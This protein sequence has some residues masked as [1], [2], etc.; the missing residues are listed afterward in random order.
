M[1]IRPDDPTL[2]E[3]VRIIFSGKNQQALS[4]LVSDVLPLF[5][6]DPRLGK[7]F[8]VIPGSEFE[9]AAHRFLRE[10]GLPETAWSGVRPDPPALIISCS[11]S[12]ELFE[13]GAKFMRL[14]HG[15]GSN[16]TRTDLDDRVYGLAPQQILHREETP[17]GERLRIPDWLPLAGEAAMELLRRNCPEAVPAAEVVG[18]LC[19]E[20]LLLSSGRERLRRYRNA[21]GIKRDQKLVVVS[22]T[23]GDESLFGT[24]RLDLVRELLASLPMDRFR[25]GVVPHPNI[26]NGRGASLRG[27]LSDQ[28]RNGLIM[29]PQHD[30]WRALLLAADVVVGDSGSVTQYAAAIGKPVLLGAFGWD[31]MTP[32]MPLWDFGKATP[33]LE[34]GK[35]FEPQIWAAIERGQPFDLGTQLAGDLTPS[36]TLFAKTYA[37]LDLEPPENPVRPKYI[38]L[39]RAEDDREPTTAWNFRVRFSGGRAHWERFPVSVHREASDTLVA[40]TEC[41]SREVLTLAKVLLCHDDV[42]PFEEARRRLEDLR[43]EWRHSLVRSVRTGEGEIL[44][45]GARHRQMRVRCE[46]ELLDI[47]PAALH[48]WLMEHPA[49][50][51]GLDAAD[52]FVRF[53]RCFEPPPT[54]LSL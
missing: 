50:S 29:P 36:E 30:L 3:P 14:S 49:D 23:W 42:V 43:E 9:A 6:P 33:G 39:L 19:L 4:R 22:S 13:T 17:E 54:L 38:G 12:P 44:V 52:A 41:D 46:P 8:S 51:S 15:A 20:R 53:E 7:E 24:G 1:S 27:V 25:V 18:D 2:P 11:P 5:D 16:R 34:F 28:L 47:V 40:R 26:E 35:P 48:A 31:Q 21:L 10:Q 45:E 37:L 32:G